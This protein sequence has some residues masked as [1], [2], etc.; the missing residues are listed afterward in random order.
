MT[1]SLSAPRRPRAAARALARDARARTR[2]G[3]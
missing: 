3:A 2:A 1:L